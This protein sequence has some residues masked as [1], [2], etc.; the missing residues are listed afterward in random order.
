MIYCCPRDHASLSIQDSSYVC[1]HGHCYPIRDGIPIFILTEVQQT[2]GEA[3][4]AL[5]ENEVTS[6]LLHDNGITPASNVLH[7]IVRGILGATSGNHY[8][9]IR[10]QIN[11]YPIPVI[12]LPSANHG[13]T[14][15]D[16]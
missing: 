9:P 2:H 12:R 14:L 13:E 8:Y 1:P 10:N 11:P 6:E 15:L 7:P 5:D 16:I 4:R 3:E